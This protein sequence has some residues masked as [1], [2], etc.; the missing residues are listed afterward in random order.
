MVTI[1]GGG[2]QALIPVVFVCICYLPLRHHEVRT[3]VCVILPAYITAGTARMSAPF[4]SHPIA[5]CAYIFY[6]VYCRVWLSGTLAYVACG[7][8]YQR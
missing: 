8:C 5:V 1:A 3:V 4:P 6:P 7:V 2:Q